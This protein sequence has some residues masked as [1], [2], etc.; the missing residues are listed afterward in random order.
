MFVTYFLSLYTSVFFPGFLFFPHCLAFLIE[1]PWI[2]F[3]VFVY[4]SGHSSRI[5]IWAA[6]GIC[7]RIFW[8]DVSYS[9]A[10]DLVDA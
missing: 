5:D 10:V 2:S 7:E 1:E 9:H 6:F 3:H 4:W 8:F